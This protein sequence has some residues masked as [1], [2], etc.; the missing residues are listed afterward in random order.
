[1]RM[2]AHTYKHFYFYVCK[3]LY[4]HN[5]F[6]IL[7]SYQN[8]NHHNLTLSLTLTITQPKYNLYPSQVFLKPLNWPLKLGE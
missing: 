2:H 3:D 1:M 8:L 5:I 6:P 7:L 4:R